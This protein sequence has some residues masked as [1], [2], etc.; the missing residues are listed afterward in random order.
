M[1]KALD[2]NV[3]KFHIPHS[4]RCSLSLLKDKHFRPARMSPLE[5]RVD[6][7][8]QGAS[9]SFGFQEESWSNEEGQNGHGLFD[10]ATSLVGST[11]N[12]ACTCQ[13]EE[14]A[15]DVQTNTCSCNAGHE[16]DGETCSDIDDC[17][18]GTD[19]CDT[20]ADCTNTAG[21]FSCACH[22]GYEEPS[23][24]TSPI[25]TTFFAGGKVQKLPLVS[26][27]PS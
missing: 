2:E 6:G 20:N 10:S 25:A 21:G 4:F 11:D 8:C 5:T 1:P 26:A 22:T 19:D 18:V 7:L 23:V 12:T 17:A 3:T 16:G 14:A 9:E 13:D 24:Q 15:F 27:H